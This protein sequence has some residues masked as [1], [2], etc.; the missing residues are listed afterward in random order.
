MNNWQTMLFSGKGRI[1]RSQYWL[2]GF[3]SFLIGWI[4]DTIINVGTNATQVMMTT[5]H[6]PPTTMIGY[7]VVAI[8]QIYTGACV[9]AKRWHD[10]DKS[11]WMYLILF[12]PIVGLIWTF[13]ECGCMDGTPGPNKHGPSPKGLGN[14]ASAF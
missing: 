2:W 1:R 13:I 4:L 14:P 12:I 3:I 11:G 10:R 7:G 5:G 8:W 6:F 9:V